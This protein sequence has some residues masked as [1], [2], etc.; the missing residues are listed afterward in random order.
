MWRLTAGAPELSVYFVL[1]GGQCLL[2][3]AAHFVERP[4]YGKQV[5]DRKQ[6]LVDDME[7]AHPGAD[8]SRGG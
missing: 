3:P 4:R 8:L 5:A 6:S 1:P 7:N 2:G